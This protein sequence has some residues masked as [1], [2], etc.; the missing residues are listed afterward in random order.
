MAGAI[1]GVKFL[2]DPGFVPLVALGVVVYFAALLAVRGITIR[3]V[4]FL[5][6]A[7]LSRGQAAEEMSGEG[8]R[9]LS[10]EFERGGI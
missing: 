10:Q 6:R 9:V 2:R 7:G 1:A 5:L 4:K 8:S 3:E